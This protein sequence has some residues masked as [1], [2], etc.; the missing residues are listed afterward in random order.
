MIPVNKGEVVWT[1]KPTRFSNYWRVTAT[2]WAN[3]MPN[4]LLLLVGASV[5]KARYFKTTKLGSEV[6]TMIY[7][8][9]MDKDANVRIISGNVLSGKQSTA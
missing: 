3:S 1:I 6:A 8:H 4:V 5:E 2:Y 9:G 7:D